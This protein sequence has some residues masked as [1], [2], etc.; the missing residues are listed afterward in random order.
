[1]AKHTIEINMSAD[2]S[3]GT[4]TCRVRLSG[5]GG[6]LAQMLASAFIQCPELLPLIHQ[7]L[8]DM[9]DVATKPTVVYYDKSRDSN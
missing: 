4:A 6:I 9:D 3:T 7:A 5:N 2:E 1:M 8:H